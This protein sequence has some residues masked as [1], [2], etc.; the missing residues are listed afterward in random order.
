MCGFCNNLNRNGVINL[1]SKK[2]ILT[3]TW[4]SPG[5]QTNNQIGVILIDKE[6][7]VV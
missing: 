3:Q 1:L 5:G 2:E 4:R 6:I 7:Q